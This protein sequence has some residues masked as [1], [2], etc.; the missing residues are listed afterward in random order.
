MRWKPKDKS[1]WHRWFAWRPVCISR[2][3]GLGGFVWL[4]TIERALVTKWEWYGAYWIYRL[5]GNQTP[6]LDVDLGKKEKAS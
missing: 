4:E 3:G 6:A 2:E 1:A 5:P